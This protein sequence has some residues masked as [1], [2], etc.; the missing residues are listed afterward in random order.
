[1]TQELFRERIEIRKQQILEENKRKLFS[2]WQTNAEEFRN[3]PTK[4]L[5]LYA[6]KKELKISMKKVPKDLLAEYPK[7]E[8]FEIESEEEALAQ[9]EEWAENRLL[10]KK[11]DD[12]EYVLTADPSYNTLKAWCTDFMYSLTRAKYEENKKQA[13]RST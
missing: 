2:L 10:E 3:L 8:F 12:I 7:L 6:K 5:A 4:Y 11:L 13:L 1:M 9:I